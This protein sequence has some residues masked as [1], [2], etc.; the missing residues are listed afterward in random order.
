MGPN[1][2]R[3]TRMTRVGRKLPRKRVSARKNG[4]STQAEKRKFRA[5]KKWKEFRER[6][7]EERKVCEITGAKL[8]KMWQLHHMDMSEENYQDITHEENYCALSWNMH[9]CVHYLFTKSK[10][11][12]WRKRVMNLIR[13]LKKMEKLN[14]V[15]DSE[16]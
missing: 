9:K 1:S 14:T 5:S 12:E 7:K 2:T 10:P 4:K 8:T 6:L 11:R 3:G 13:I 16:K 15:P